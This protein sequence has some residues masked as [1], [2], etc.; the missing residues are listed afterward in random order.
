VEVEKAED[1]LP[2]FGG[3]KREVTTVDTSLSVTDAQV[4]GERTWSP[5][6]DT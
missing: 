6:K 5:L 1:R 3:A 4:R 2:R